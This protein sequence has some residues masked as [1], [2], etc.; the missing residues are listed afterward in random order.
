M[1]EVKKNAYK[2]AYTELN[3]IFKIMSEDELNKIP[4]TFIANVQKEMDNDYEFELDKDKD[5][6]DQDLMTETKALIVQMYV[7][8]LALKDENEFWQKYDK[9]CISEIEKQKRKQY[10][11]DNLF[12]NKQRWSIEE[13]AQTENIAMVKYEKETFIDKIKRFFKKI[14]K[15]N[16][17]IRKIN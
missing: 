14:L 11:P 9:Y 8:F 4:S 16:D 3:E 7:R 1:T 15:K 13:Q 10:N 12:K 17:F 5:L 2:R 6:L